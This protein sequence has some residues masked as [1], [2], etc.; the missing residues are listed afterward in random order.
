MQLVER[1]E[2]LGALALR[3]RVEGR[4]VQS[5][6]SIRMSSALASGSVSLRLTV[7]RFPRGACRRLRSM[8][9]ARCRMMSSAK[10]VGPPT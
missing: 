10:P 5:R 8:N 2:D 4:L 7:A 1:A 9:N 6:A 3:Q